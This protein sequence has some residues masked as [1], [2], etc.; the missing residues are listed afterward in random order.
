MNRFL[1]DLFPC[2][3]VSPNRAATLALQRCIR[4][5]HPTSRGDGDGDGVSR[6]VLMEEEGVSK[7]KGKLSGLLQL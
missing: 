7:G 6:G 1:P 3:C 4:G 2:W 5:L